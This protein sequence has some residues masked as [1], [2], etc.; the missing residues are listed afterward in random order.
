M[1]KITIWIPSMPQ[2]SYA[3]RRG[4]CQVIHDDNH[5]AIIID[6]GEDDICNKAISYCKSHGISHITYI[7][8]H[9]HYDHDRGMKLLLDSS[10]I[11]DRID[12]VATGH[13][14]EVREVA[15]Q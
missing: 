2:K 7:L 5:N 6:G 15:D 11:V 1:S 14:V 8:S 13:V 3:Y 10:L 12:R 4:D 9:W